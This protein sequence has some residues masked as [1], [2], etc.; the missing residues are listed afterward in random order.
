[1][2][3]IVGVRCLLKFQFISYKHQQLN[4]SIFKKQKHVSVF[5]INVRQISF[6]LWILTRNVHCT[7]RLRICTFTLLKWPDTFYLRIGYIFVLAWKIQPIS[8]I[9]GI[10]NKNSIL[11]KCYLVL[12]KILC[13]EL[14]RQFCRE[15]CR[16]KT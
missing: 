4:F 8:I 1:M 10:L 15:T 6:S 14:H 3:L 13:S 2:L 7:I 11:R 16:Y 12:T 9:F 5:V